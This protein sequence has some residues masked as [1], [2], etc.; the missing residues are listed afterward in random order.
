MQWIA[1]RYFA[2][3]S[4]WIDAASWRAVRVHLSAPPI[5]EEVDWNEPCA[6]PAKLRHP[7]LNPLIDYGIGPNGCRFEVYERSE[8]LQAPASSDAAE[9]A[10]RHAAQF[11]RAHAVMIPA[12]VAPFALR[13]V[14]AG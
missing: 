12:A 3:G 5:V 14:I 1:E 2:A 6:R 10:M 8:P 9:I 13:P 4:E 11:L 7:L